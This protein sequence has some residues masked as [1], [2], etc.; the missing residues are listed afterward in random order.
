M[1][2]VV[3]T[4]AMVVVALLSVFALF[5]RT[6]TLHNYCLSYYSRVLLND[7]RHNFNAGRKTLCK[8]LFKI[9]SREIHKNN[10]LSLI[11]LSTHQ[12]HMPPQSSTDR[13][14]MQP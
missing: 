1:G 9:M 14:T 8:Q 3:I 6:F 10:N 4:T 2:V 7:Y 5:L 13:G 12:P 11:R